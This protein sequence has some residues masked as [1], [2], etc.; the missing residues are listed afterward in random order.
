MQHYYRVSKLAEG[1]FRIYDPMGVHMDLFVGHEKALLFDTG[2]GLVNLRDT[3]R[4]IT[5]LP[6]IIV[7]SHGHV[8]H[9]CGNYQF[10]EPIHI[11]PA[12]VPVCEA[13][14]LA[15]QKNIVLRYAKTAVDFFTG[16]PVHAITPEFDEWKYLAQPMGNFVPLAE[17]EIFDLGGLQLEVVELPGH[18]EGSIGL[19]LKDE[20]TLYAAD[21]INNNVWLFQPEAAP[22]SVYRSTLDKAWNLDF[23]TLIISHFPTPLEKE[24][25][26]DYM[27]V[28]DHLDYN[29]GFPFS[30]PLAPDADAKLCVRDGFAPDNMFAPGFASIVIS[31][32]KL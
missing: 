30:A 16:E 3:V 12:D 13:H 18:T 29:K 2:F 6:L 10:D 17:G 32:D 19:L 7:N 24:V 5:E 25:I 4:E 26:L 8:D 14:H 31:E 20:K 15:Y 28:A 1:R 22:L 9:A 11:H 27:D 23:N 21:A